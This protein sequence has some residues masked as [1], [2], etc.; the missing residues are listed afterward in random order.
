MSSFVS[1]VEAGP[2]ASSA[3]S[4]STVQSVSNSTT[5]VLPAVLQDQLLAIIPCYNEEKHVAAVVEQLLRQERGDLLTIV[6]VDGASTDGTAR[7]AREL[8]ERYPNVH[9]LYNEARIQSAAIN[10]AVRELGDD[11]EFVV[12][13]DAHADYPVDYC[14]VLVDEAK[15]MQADSV[16]VSMQT[17][18]NET[19]FQG[20]A[21]AAQN[22]KLGNGG[23]AHRRQQDNG[24]WVEH[25]HHALIRV[26]AFRA[27]GGYDELFTH[28]ED[29]EFDIRLHHAG[30]RCWLTSRTELNYY[31]RKDPVRLFRQYVNYGQ[32]RART[33]LKHRKLPKVRQMLPLLVF[34]AFLFS[35]LSFFSVFAAI[36]FLT[37][38]CA[39][40]IYGLALGARDRSLTSALS[41]F[42]AMIIHFGWS[43]GFWRQIVRG[44]GVRRRS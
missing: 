32:G 28:N 31:P 19:F 20:V 5:G 24:R 10:K 14:A 23:S 8:C 33:F 2:I 9:Y 13:V 38:A 41:G 40:I 21:A 39:C 36:P 34:P 3:R 29:A 12:R 1:G 22:S 25:G 11:F 15:R 27:I 37:W 42:A 26:E 43:Y 16:V 17:A 35:F 18:G 4:S 7:I 44:S 30:Y 6:V